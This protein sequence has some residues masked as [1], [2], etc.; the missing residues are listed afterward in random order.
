M[1][2]GV[3]DRLGLGFETLK[4]ANPAIVFCSLSG[5]G[6]DGPYAK[7]A[8][9]GP[10][11]DA[12]GGIGLPPGAAIDRWEGPQPTPVG[13]HA[14]GL[15][16]ALATLAAVH[17]ARR[18]GEGVAVEIAAAECSAHWLPDALDPL[19]N[20]G[21]T[22]IRPGFLDGDGRMARW[23]R[24]ENYRCADGKLL[25]L[26]S[27]TDKSWRKLLEVVGRADLD[28]IYARA[29]LTGR[30]DAEVRDAL[31]VLFATEERAHWLGLATRHDLA[32]MPVNTPA[33]LID[34]PHFAS[35]PNVYAS[36]LP[37]GT[38]LTLT[39]TPMR[40]RGQCFDAAPAPDL[41]DHDAAIRAEFGL[42]RAEEAV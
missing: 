15:S 40:V 42:E 12:F 22:R 39:S 31:A 11:F 18:T 14:C 25:Y 10:S 5:L 32:I 36:R 27:H 20:P 33:D 28:A 16:G 2:A 7:R 19:L 34:D 9:H 17:R 24:M 8:S 37:D 1:R 29:P 23:A 21:V 6:E 3:L 26:M 4:Q 38:P 30:E 35:R 41:G 13:M